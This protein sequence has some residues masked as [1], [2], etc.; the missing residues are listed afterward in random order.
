[1][2]A[3]KK[4]LYLQKRGLTRS[5]DLQSR[6]S[7]NTDVIHSKHPFIQNYPRAVDVTWWALSTSSGVLGHWAVTSLQVLTDTHVGHGGR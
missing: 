1:M 5:A 3:F 6:V 7:Y 2:F 4:T